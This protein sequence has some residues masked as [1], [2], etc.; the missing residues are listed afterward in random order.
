MLVLFR[1]L[2]YRHCTR[3]G[4]DNEVVILNEVKGLLYNVLT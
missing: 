2:K 4:D 1:K 3:W